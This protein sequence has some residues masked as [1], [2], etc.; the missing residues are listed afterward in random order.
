MNQ[1]VVERSN[2]IMER[3]RAVAVRHPELPAQLSG[4]PRYRCL[5]FGGLKILVVHGD[6]EA[7]AGRG[8]SRETLTDEGAG[9]I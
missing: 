8:L 7:L 9:S 5:M 2:R 1:A 6:P 3:V 4:L